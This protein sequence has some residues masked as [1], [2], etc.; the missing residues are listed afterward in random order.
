MQPGY[1]I[2]LGPSTARARSRIRIAASSAARI[3]D[4][5]GARSAKFARSKVR[6]TV[7]TLNR[8]CRARGSEAS[9]A[10]TCSRG[11]LVGARDRPR[12]ANVL[13]NEA[14]IK[15]MRRWI[16]GVL[17]SQEADGWFG[18]SRSRYDWD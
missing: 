18:P 8:S 4:S 12:A 10:S 9:S 3:S 15:E 5:S 6:T 11:V 2:D 14:I 7:S 16:E 1:R 13:H 17:S